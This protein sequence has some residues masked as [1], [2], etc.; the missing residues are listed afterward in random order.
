[1]SR[2]ANQASFE[3]SAL[4]RRVQDGDHGAFEGLVLKYQDRIHNACYRM[5]NDREAARDMAQEAF[6][7]AYEALSRFEHK[8]SFY[9][10][11][12][13]IAVNLCISQRRRDRR[14][15]TQSSDH[16]AESL[17]NPQASGQALKLRAMV[18]EDQS[19]QPAEVAH[20]RETR[21]AVMQALSELDDDQR[22]ILVLREL[23][24]FD[25]QAIA[26]ILKIPIGT[27]RSRL[28]R[29]RLAL[30]ERLRPGLEKAG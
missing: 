30:K 6:V 11:L 24:S 21:S 17:A 20:R 29:A 2:D 9:T 8:S 28:H 26:D 5:T 7:K 12:F 15:T 4:V 22:A 27:V 3:D 25:Y 13:R 10:W 18:T 14:V 23:E 19:A 16:I 1:M